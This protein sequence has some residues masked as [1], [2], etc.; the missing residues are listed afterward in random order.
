MSF[1]KICGITD[2]REIEE[3]NKLKV[4][5]AGFILFF[6][7]SKRNNSIKKAI[8]L[9]ACL[10]YSKAVAVTVSPTLE[11]ALAIE[12]AG[13]DVLQVHGELSDEIKEK[14][15]IEIWKAFNIS[16]KEEQ[17]GENIRELQLIITDNRISGIV[18]D[19]AVAGSGESFDWKQFK[20]INTR[21]KLFIM[22]GGLCPENVKSAI[23]SLSP[24]VVDVSS[25]VEYPEK[26]RVG[27]D[28]KRVRKFVE[29]VRT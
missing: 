5:Y 14:C 10:T 29:N 8:E 17:N 22:A 16:A 28:L 27:K 3:L 15:N 11:Q 9:K 23:E 13:F 12:Q 2:E 26:D 20:K 1:I 19:G 25:G 6:P 4:E 24:D 18:I 7:K 21:E